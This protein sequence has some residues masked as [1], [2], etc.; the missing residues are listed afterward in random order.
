M[1]IENRR[2]IWHAASR[3]RCADESFPM[4]VVCWEH[5]TKEALGLLAKQ[6]M[7]RADQA[8][9]ALHES[10]C[11]LNDIGRAL[12]AAGVHEDSYVEC[13]GIL[14]SR[15]PAPPAGGKGERE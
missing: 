9:A 3:N 5:A 2:C 7:R 8:E 11:A 6:Q 12:T 1:S 4:L 10:T 15:F 14:A 13:I